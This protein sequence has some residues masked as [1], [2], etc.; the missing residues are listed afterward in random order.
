GRPLPDRALLA[1]LGRGAGLRRR[2][3][4]LPGRARGAAEMSGGEPVAEE[5]CWVPA[6]ELAAMVRAREVSPSEIAEAAI[7][8]VERVNPKLNAI[9]EYDPE[10]IRAR[11]RRLT[12]ELADG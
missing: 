6:T 12:D 8:R 7:A 4:R 11:A 10:A 1:A 2:P 9:I 3:R 5:L